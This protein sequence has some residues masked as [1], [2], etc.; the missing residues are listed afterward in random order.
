MQAIALIRLWR[1][2][3]RPIS[4]NLKVFSGNWL[5]IRGRFPKNL[6]IFRA[7]IGRETILSRRGDKAPS[8]V[9]I[10]IASDVHAAGGVVLGLTSGRAGF[11]RDL[12]WGNSDYFSD[13]M[14]SVK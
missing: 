1:L 10:A 6:R 13:S 4:Y 14:E 9:K 7:E 2:A 11:A 3:L 8:L 12:G 5:G